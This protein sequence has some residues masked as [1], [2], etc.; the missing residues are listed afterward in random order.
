VGSQ[1]KFLHCWF[2]LRNEMKWNASLASV[3]SANDAPVGQAGDTIKDDTLPPMIP[4]P[5][6]RDKSKKQR[7][8]S[9]SSNSNSSA[10]LEVL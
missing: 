3:S 1:F 9:T 8:S 10:Y 7:N 4:R 5:P 6:G 2:I